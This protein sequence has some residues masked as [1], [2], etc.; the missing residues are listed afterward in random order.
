MVVQV[1]LPL[2]IS[3]QRKSAFA[4][5]VIAI[6]A[7]AEVRKVAL[8]CT[9][10]VIEIVAAPLV[11]NSI[12]QLAVAVIA[13]GAVMEVVRTRVAVFDA[14]IVIV[15]KAVVVAIVAASAVAVM[16]I[17]AVADVVRTRLASTV[18]VSAIVALPVPRCMTRLSS[19]SS[20][21]Y[22]SRASMLPHASS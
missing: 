19:C 12:L 4:V 2:A 11:R 17:G 5:A 18:A 7:D 13:I 21:P 15:A 9:L 3:P 10:P 1:S 14:V 20:V 22:T 6:G 16:A 8:G